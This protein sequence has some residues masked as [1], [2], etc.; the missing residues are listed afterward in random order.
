MV[1]GIG[2]A[3]R[4]AGQ[5]RPRRGGQVCPPVPRPSGGRGW[6]SRVR[7]PSLSGNNRAPR[8]GCAKPDT[9][10]NNWSFAQTGQPEHTFFGSRNSCILF[11]NP[12]LSTLNFQPVQS[13]TGAKILRFMRAILFQPVRQWEIKKI[14]ILH[15]KLI[16]FNNK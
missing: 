5:T 9:A 14:K 13:V 15:R 12:Q 2:A 7:E 11:L 8:R 10:D 1:N 4:V 16:W 3:R 6:R